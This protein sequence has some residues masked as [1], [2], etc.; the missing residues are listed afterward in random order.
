V[1]VDAQAISFGRALASVISSFTDFAGSDGC[2]TS[3]PTCVASGM[4]PM[5]S[6]IVS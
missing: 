1:P 3:M 5:K 4:M 2:T 6:R